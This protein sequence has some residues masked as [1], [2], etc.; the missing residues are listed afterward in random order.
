LNRKPAMQI[1][2]PHQDMNNLHT[3]IN[4]QQSSPIS[5]AKS[6]TFFQRPA[7]GILC[8]G[9]TGMSKFTW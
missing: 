9:I 1:C 8:Q 5:I 4:N 2:H 7:I 6:I 3:T